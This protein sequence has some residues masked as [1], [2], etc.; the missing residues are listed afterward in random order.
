MEI[1]QFVSQILHCCDVNTF[2]LHTHIHSQLTMS[3]SNVSTNTPTNKKRKAE[4]IRKK[5]GNVDPN[6]IMDT[7]TPVSVSSKPKKKHKKEPIP[8]TETTSTV[9]TTI[10]TSPSFP[11]KHEK[12]T[13]ILV[14]P[15]RIIKDSSPIA[16]QILDNRLLNIIRFA[17][18]N[19][20]IIIKYH[21]DPE[22]MKHTDNKVESATHMMLMKNY[23]TTVRSQVVPRS[24]HSIQQ[25]LNVFSQQP[26]YLNQPVRTM[27][28]QEC[29]PDYEPKKLLE[30]NLP[31]TL[32]I[33]IGLRD[34]LDFVASNR[35]LLQ[36]YKLDGIRLKWKWM[37][38]G[39]QKL[40]IWCNRKCKSWILENRDYSIAEDIYQGTVWDGEL[41]LLED[42]KIVAYTI[43]DSLLSCGNVS[44]AKDKVFRLSV[45]HHNIEDWNRIAPSSVIPPIPFNASAYSVE[46]WIRPDLVVRVKRF[47]GFRDAAFL[48]DRVNPSVKQ[49]LDGLI[50]E[51]AEDSCLVPPKK[52][53]L[54]HPID[55]QIRLHRINESKNE[56]IYSVWSY[57]KSPW[58]WIEWTEHGFLPITFQ[59][60]EGTQSFKERH[61]KITEVDIHEN[62]QGQKWLTFKCFRDQEK[63][64]PNE[65]RVV[66]ATVAQ[67]RQNI[68][69]DE[70]FPREMFDQGYRI[71]NAADV[72]EARVKKK[73]GWTDADSEIQSISLPPPIIYTPIS[74]QQLQK[75]WKTKCSPY[76][77]ENKVYMHS[78]IV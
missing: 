28:F 2:I 20:K 45:A 47:Y 33:S 24:E 35:F 71:K 66:R 16:Y 6:V 74:R 53:K 51:N 52:Y 21:E 76:S 5:N 64:L 13:V 75:A 57:Q 48:L 68:Q 8:D 27:I 50:I 29:E 18:E 46:R 65:I 70:L 37:T 73:L 40:S 61:N 44:G 3:S 38:V 63:T 14:R 15:W 1:T 59:Q 34:L 9:P 19:L 49:K 56:G 60:L 78:R 22:K 55:F 67:Y 23:H 54:G 31:F 77:D 72:I 30:T 41:T 17:Y 10:T 39:S 7:P 43:F 26:L 12:A 36:T 11:N 4:I 32:P 69:W 58:A 42:G 25:N 62:E